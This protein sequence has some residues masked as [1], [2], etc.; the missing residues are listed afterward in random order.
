MN[1]QSAKSLIRSK[2]TV[3][4]GYTAS[5]RH[6]DAVIDAL[7][8]EIDRTTAVM[9]KQG[10]AIDRMQAQIDDDAETVR[11]AAGI[12]LRSAEFDYS[13]FRIDADDIVAEFEGEAKEGKMHIGHS[14][15]IDDDLFALYG[16]HRI[17]DIG[18]KYR[19]IIVADN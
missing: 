2:V 16:F 3:A 17:L 10:Q 19:V 4:A 8:D 6:A 14:T 9:L 18:K 1:R 11:K 13:G 5:L 15:V 12:L 7:F